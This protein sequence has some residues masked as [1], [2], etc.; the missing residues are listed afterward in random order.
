[1]PSPEDPLARH[2]AER[3]LRT[4]VVG[5]PLSHP[6]KLLWPADGITKRALAE[7][8]ERVA[9]PLLAYAGGRPLTL[10]RAPDGIGGKLFFQRHAG[11][12]GS[13]PLLRTVTL[14]GEEK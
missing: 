4:E 5:V 8:L 10:V 9:G 13:S 3:D 1:M 6:D 12:G 11:P 14:A 2:R 7:Y